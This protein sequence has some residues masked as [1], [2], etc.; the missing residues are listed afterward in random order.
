MSR[1]TFSALI[2]LVNSGKIKPNVAKSYPLREIANAQS[3]FQSKK[4]VGKLIL[5]P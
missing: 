4:Y 3:D 2:E 1:Q 5:L